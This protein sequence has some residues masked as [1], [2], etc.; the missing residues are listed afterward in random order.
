MK[1]ILLVL[2]LC[3]PAMVVAQSNP[4]A[5]VAKS[6]GD[7][8]RTCESATQDARS[9]HGL[10]CFAW[11]SGVIEGMDAGFNGCKTFPYK[12]PANITLG[13]IGKISVKYINDHPESMNRPT[14]LL[15]LWALVD[16]Y[17]TKK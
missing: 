4:F 3:L 12:L 1:H 10:E 9:P 8:I 13:Q 16:A 15:V 2:L 7:F 11:L 14:S 17:P 6:G 5:D